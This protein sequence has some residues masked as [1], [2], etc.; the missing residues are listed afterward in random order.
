L[1]V[2]DV[3]QH[4]GYVYAYTNRRKHTLELIQKVA[5]PCARILD[6]AAG[7]GNFSIMLAE[8][9]YEVT[10]NDIREDL[11]DYTRLKHERGVIHYRPGNI[12]ELC[13]DE[14]FDVVLITEIIE[15]VAHPDEFLRK[16]SR[17]IRPDGHVVMTTPNGEYFLN[18]LPRFS[19]CANPGQFEAMQF[20]PNS[21]GHIFL[22]HLDEVEALAH[23][24][25]LKVIEAR[26]FTNPLT[27]GHIKT[28]AILKITPRSWINA[29]EHLTT[30]SSSIIKKKIH[31]GMAV[32]FA[33][34]G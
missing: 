24:T 12:L 23:E 27:N 33:R 15:H 34:A 10:W 14:Y 17:M 6:V 8:L 26:V 29:F 18:S 25:G 32:L 21:E 11:A 13:F 1:E 19:D 16:I 31:A 5:S 9:G 28:G 2:D 7:Q 4:T 30:S 22:L 3:S 20:Q